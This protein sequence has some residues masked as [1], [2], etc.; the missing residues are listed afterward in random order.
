MNCQ[1]AREL[2]ESVWDLPDED[3][4]R[5]R[6]NAHVN[7]CSACAAEY[8]LWLQSLNMV[9][10]LEEEDIPGIDSERINRNVMDRIYRDFPWLVE[11]TSKS[12]AV[13][14]VFRKRLTLWI[15]GFL[16]LFVCSFIYF[17]VIESPAKPA[18]EAV[19]TGII[20]TGI[21]D[22]GQSLTGKDYNIPKTNS[23]I[24]DPFVVGMSPTEPQYWMLLSL[25]SVGLAMY[26]LMRLN[27]VRR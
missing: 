26:F 17:A 12:R 2:M 6:L 18:P 1:E 21:A 27:R 24:I 11:E 7:T 14:R 16:A 4:R 10:V 15:A 8:E 25:L 9:H 20:P 13:S 22:T 5:Q 23:G 19:A 3:P